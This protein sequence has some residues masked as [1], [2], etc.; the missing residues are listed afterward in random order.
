MI[1]VRAPGLR[2]PGES[3]SQVVEPVAPAQRDRVRAALGT[4]YV[5]DREIGRGGMA[6]VYVAHDARH[7]RLVA[8]KVLDPELASAL[9][10]ARF[11]REIRIAAQLQHP[12]ILPVYDSGAGRGVLWFAMP[13]VEGQTLRQ[14]LRSEKRPSVGEA[15]SYLIDLAQALAYAH[16]RGIIHRDV[17]PENVL[18]G[19]GGVF[20]MDF[21]IAKPLDTSCDAQLTSAGLVVGTPTYMAPEQAAAGP[22]DHRADIYALGVLGYELL[23]GEPPFANLPLGALIAA[24]AIREPEPIQRHRPEVPAPI[25]DAIAR[26]LRKEPAERWSTA[27]ELSLALGGIDLNAIPTGG[28]VAAAVPTPP[29]T[30]PEHLV[31]GRAAFDRAAW[32]D[33]YLSFA[34][35]HT[36]VEL[37]AEDLERLGEAAWWVSDGPTALR[38]REKAYRRYV[39][40]GDLPRAAWVALA[41]AED[42][43]HRQARSAGHGWLRRAERHL[44]G[45]PALPEHGWLCRLQMQRVLETDGCSDEA[46]MLAERS[47][48][49]ARR[50]GDT[51]LQ[52]L[53]LQDRGRILVGLGRVAEGMALIE[54]AMTAAT[55][56]ELSPHTTGRTFCNMMGTCHRLGD[57][58]RA[59]EWHEV[60]QAWAEPHSESGFPGICRVYRASILRLRGD[61]SEAEREAK[62]AVEEL[63][64]FMVDIA[65]EAFYELGEIYFRQGD[66]R[67]ADS[68]F[69]EA[70]MRGRNPQPGLSVLR[71]AEGDSEAA[72][73][74]IERA[75]SAPGLGS[76][77]RTNLLPALVEIN[78]ACRRLDA[79]S[80][81][82]NELERITRTYTSAALQA[83]AALARG[84]VELAVGRPSESLGELQR[85]QRLWNDI[86]L[87]YEL[88]RTRMLMARAYSLLGAVEESRLEERSARATLSRM[89]AVVTE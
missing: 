14:R 66:L 9:G 19:E 16:R 89:G 4:R 23:A 44:E 27:A 51:D 25:W 87:P 17:K 67:L 72:L 5:L 37:E 61:L 41:L 78:I 53:A 62:R 15:L 58:G 7:E 32:R 6:T 55:A 30:G 80:E 1:Q 56:G 35:A 52:A 50:T 76:L 40:R 31:H 33:A 29:A 75:V 45:L 34:A 65:G 60:G 74:M 49:I 79:A 20:L 48:E 13:Y 21:G 77:D 68:M 26:C 36:Q 47:L 8:I 83:A 73:G 63:K 84:M 22:T 81:A 11:Q 46:M 82:A 2:G 54:D 43:F 69:I 38:A 59:A 70:H 85:A 88:A 42:Y 24:H 3:M 12:H 28:S 71:L 86:E 18:L 10:P 39:Q 57:V 64:G